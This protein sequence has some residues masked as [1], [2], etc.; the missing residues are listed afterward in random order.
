M[1]TTPLEVTVKRRLLRKLLAASVL[2]ATLI[3]MT[4]TESPTE[5]R[6]CPY[7]NDCVN[8][9][10]VCRDGCLGDTT[11]ITYCQEEYTQCQCTN[12][13]LCRRDPSDPRLKFPM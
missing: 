9:Y 8:F 5:A 12:C 13:N 3:F 7:Y 6:S 2:A 4:L 1:L 10:Y 11:C